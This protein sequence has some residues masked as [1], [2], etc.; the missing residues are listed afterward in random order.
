M[1]I[2]SK[3]YNN[4][5]KVVYQTSSHSNTT[6]I[7]IFVKV[8][9]I[10]EDS[11]LYGISHFIEHMVFKGTETNKSSKIISGHFDKI[12]A[13]INAYTDY[14]NTCYVVKCDSDYFKTS[15]DMLGDILLNSEMEKTEFDKEKTVVVDEIIRAKDNIENY[16]NEKIYELIFRGSSFENSIGGTQDKIMNYDITKCKKY[17][18]NFYNPGNMVVSICSNISFDDIISILDNNMLSKGEYNT[19]NNI[20][21]RPNLEITETCLK[22]LGLLSKNELEQIYISIGFKVEGRHSNDIYILTLLKIIL[23]GNMSSLLFNNLRENR[24][25]TY[26]IDIDYSVYDN[27]GA[28]IILTGVDKEKFFNYNGKEGALEVIIDKLQF[29]KDKKITENDLIIAKGFIKGQLSLSNDDTLNIASYKG[30]NVLFNTKDSLCNYSDLF[31]NRYK[32]I[33]LEDINKIIEKY[34]CKDN[35]SSFY[36]GKNLDR[37]IKIIE[38]ILSIQDKL[39]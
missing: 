10:Y 21:Y 20:D 18:K 12:G 37:N 19:F 26:S 33:S 14:D 13:Y 34:I 30:K 7:N 1:N 16:I 29:I 25:L 38:R 8:G 35:L 9:S 17:Y 36:I 6:T 22:K 28:F 32:D 39:S 15:M 5:L 24:G 4:G 31:N 23:S 3:K 2:N 27:F 11:D